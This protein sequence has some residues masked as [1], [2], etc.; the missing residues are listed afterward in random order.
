MGEGGLLSFFDLKSKRIINYFLIVSK[1]DILKNSK[2]LC[3]T[4]QISQ[5]AT[6][7][8]GDRIVFTFRITLTHTLNLLRRLFISGLINLIFF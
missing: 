1:N 7:S 6:G 3:N 2:L 4:E 5:Q 8:Q